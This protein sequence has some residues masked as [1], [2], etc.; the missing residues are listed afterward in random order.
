MKETKW[1]HTVWPRVHFRVPVVNGIKAGAT[2]VCVLAGADVLSVGLPGGWRNTQVLSLKE[3]WMWRAAPRQA[4]SS[5]SRRRL[6]YAVL[7]MCCPSGWKG[8]G[9]SS[10]EF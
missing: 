1:K 6:L 4:D 3:L 2:A 5:T 10:W 9:V 8:S 7:W